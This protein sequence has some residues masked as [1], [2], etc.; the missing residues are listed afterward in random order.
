MNDLINATLSWILDMIMIVVGLTGVSSNLFDGLFNDVLLAFQLADNYSR[1]VKMGPYGYPEVFVP[2]AAAPY[3]LDGIFA[4]KR[5]MWNT[6]GYVSGMV[7]FQNGLPYEVG[8]DIQPGALATIIRG[9][10]IYTD[11]IENVIISDTRE[12]RALVMVQVG[13]GQAEEAPIVRVQRR[14]VQATRSLAAILLTPE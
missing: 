9:G 2:T 10:K 3:S 13:D 4:M 5:E 1:R 8:R 12:E 14:I 6:R 7:S 11:Y